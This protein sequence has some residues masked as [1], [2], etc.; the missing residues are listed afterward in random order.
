M[1]LCHERA[2]GI[3]IDDTVSL[4]DFDAVLKGLKNLFRE[5]QKTSQVSSRL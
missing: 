2:Q 1:E 5:A 4:N 3:I